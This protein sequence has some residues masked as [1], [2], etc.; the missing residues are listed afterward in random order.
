MEYVSDDG[1]GQ[2]RYD[3]PKSLPKK[4][5]LPLA[6][7]PL[8]LVFLLVGEQFY[9]ITHPAAICRTIPQSTIPREKRRHIRNAIY[10]VNFFFFLS[11]MVFY[12]MMMMK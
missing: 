11:S 4:S 2:I 10:I 12:F 3:A 9:R 1:H 6:L 8:T 7:I 5:N